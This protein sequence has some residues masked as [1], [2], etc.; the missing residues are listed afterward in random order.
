MGIQCDF[1]DALFGDE[2]LLVVLP[3]S[4]IRR[5]EAHK[6]KMSP[7]S[8]GSE[9]RRQLHRTLSMQRNAVKRSNTRTQICS[10]WI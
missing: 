10:T 1:A 3:F 6:S 4:V 7:L 9:Q 2:L 8:E 5:R